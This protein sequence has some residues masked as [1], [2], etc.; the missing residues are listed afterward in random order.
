[1]IE[2]V[3]YPFTLGIDPAFGRG[4]FFCYDS[5]MPIE[6]E[7]PFPPSSNTYYRSVRMGQS[8]R[9]LLSKRGREYKEEVKRI[10]FYKRKKFGLPV[11]GRLFVGVRLHAPNR[12]KYDIDNRIKALSDAL[13]FAEVFADDEAIDRLLVT[14]HEII[15]G[16]LAV[17]TIAQLEEEQT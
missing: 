5:T 16:G 9:V 10:M 13:Q 17:V 15:K 12:R 3:S 11:E 1:L 6:F 7:L 8:C 14:R 2:R 4:L